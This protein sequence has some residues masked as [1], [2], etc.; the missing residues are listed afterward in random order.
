MVSTVI[1]FTGHLDVDVA[2]HVAFE[3]LA[4]MSVLD[5]WNPSVKASRRVEGER[6]AVGSRYESIIARGPLRMTATSTL[7]A[8]DPGRSVRYEGA[9]SVFWSIDELRFDPSRAGCRVTFLNES[10]MPAWLRPVG[11]LLNAAFQPQARKAVFG[12]ERFLS[13]SN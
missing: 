2:P 10:R 6:L 4:D 11:P 7:T 5:R 1:R 3:R 9:I 13:S 12:A 8:I